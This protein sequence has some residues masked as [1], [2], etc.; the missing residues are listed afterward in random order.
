MENM[1][2]RKYS[3]DYEVVETTDEKGKKRKEVVYRGDYY[4][5]SLEEEDI[6]K[7]KK[8]SFLLLI[9]IGVFHLIGGFMNTQGMYQFYISF[10]YIFGFLPI[11]YLAFGVFRLPKEKRKYQREEVGSSF[12]RIKKSSKILLILLGFGI[13]G[14]IAYL[15]FIADEGPLMLDY[16]YLVLEMLVGYS[17]YM[18]RR[19]QN[20]IIVQ[21][22]TE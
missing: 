8:E 6:K 15:L 3:N 5:I 16:I 4:E 14:E 18:M 12:E 22:S 1:V 9:P 20:N 10:P 11:F 7:F 17:V 21:K 13:V 19:R 2:M